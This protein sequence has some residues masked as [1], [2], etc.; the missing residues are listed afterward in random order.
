LNIRE[1]RR[2]GEKER[3]REKEKAIEREREREREKEKDKNWIRLSALWNCSL[4][5]SSYTRML[6]NT[7][8]ALI[9]VSWVYNAIYGCE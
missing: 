7:V 5:Q 4:F 2:E 6:P 8:I 9:V 1:K 3:E